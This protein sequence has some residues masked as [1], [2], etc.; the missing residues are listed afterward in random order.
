P[1]GL[2]Q[3]GHGTEASRTQETR[4]RW[5]SKTPKRTP[6]SAGRLGIIYDIFTSRDDGSSLT[7]FD[8]ACRGFRRAFEVAPRQY[9]GECRFA[10][11]SR[12]AL[13]PAPMAIRLRIP[14]WTKSAAVK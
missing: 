8:D 5:A 11:K 1:G 2:Q 3:F 7:A 13:R 9:L 6:V 14:A 10:A 12:T 4:S